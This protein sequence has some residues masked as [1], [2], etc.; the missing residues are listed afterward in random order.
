MGRG[1]STPPSPIPPRET[2]LPR[3]PRCTPPHA[4][5]FPMCPMLCRKYTTRGRKK[6]LP[7]WARPSFRSGR[8]K[9]APRSGA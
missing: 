2:A 7:P 8:G 4:P 1:G 5:P 6:S 9:E 3:L